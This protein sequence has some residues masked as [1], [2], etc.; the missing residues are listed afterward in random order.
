[1]QPSRLQRIILSCNKDAINGQLGGETPPE[2]W[3]SGRGVC[4][5]EMIREGMKSIVIKSAR[6][7]NEKALVALRGG[8]FEAL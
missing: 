5:L 2:L 3:G 8:R 6:E 4:L 7:A 1:M